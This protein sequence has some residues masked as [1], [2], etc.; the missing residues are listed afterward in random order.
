METAQERQK[1]NFL[2]LTPGW[3][4]CGLVL[5]KIR[6]LQGTWQ[7]DRAL[8]VF[9]SMSSDTD[10]SIKCRDEMQRD[11]VQDTPRIMSSLASE[12]DELSP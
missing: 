9:C 3:T 11:D 6:S 8:S 10:M 2:Y 7:G 4:D 5:E 1:R 12:N